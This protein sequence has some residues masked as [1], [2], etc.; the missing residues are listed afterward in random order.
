MTLEEKQQYLNS[1]I[2]QQNYDGNE[3]SAFISSIRGEQQVDLDTWSFEDL[4]AVVA[5]F[6]A[7]YQQ[8][9]D[10]QENQN[11]QNVN[12]EEQNQNQ[13]YEESPNQENS[14]E[15]G[16]EQK[17]EKKHSSE[18]DFPDNLLA[19]L[20]LVIKTLHLELNEISDNNDLF[21]TISNPQR[22]KPGLLSLPYY[23]YDMQTQ[24][25]GYKVVRKVS[26]YTFLYE[27]LP[28]INCAVFNP[29]LPHF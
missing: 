11:E 16:E 18:N 9:Q 20:T 2:I 4:Q 24:P 17:I 3:F 23:Q 26:D 6:K 10:N 28:I 19:P 8:K 1:E 7:Q 22:L 15:N 12:N 27:T 25:V 29:I 14:P 21:I 5:Q 13:A